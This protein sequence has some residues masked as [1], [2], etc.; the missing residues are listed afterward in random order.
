MSRTTK[1][2][3]RK[4]EGLSPKVLFSH[5]LC[6]YGLVRALFDRAAVIFLYW[7]CCKLSNFLWLFF[8]NSNLILISNKR[9]QYTHQFKM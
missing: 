9:Y 3:Q 8:I 7:F 2:K 5:S 4:C 6:L 1:E